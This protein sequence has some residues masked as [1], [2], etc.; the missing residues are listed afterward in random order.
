MYKIRPLVACDTRSATAQREDSGV[1]REGLT[2]LSSTT[3]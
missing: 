3:S 1:A 2:W